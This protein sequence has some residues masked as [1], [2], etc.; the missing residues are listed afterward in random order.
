VSERENSI[1]VRADRETGLREGGKG[2]DLGSEES[3]LLSL[4]NELKI[5]SQWLH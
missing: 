2:D 5:A 4:L 1:V 3:L